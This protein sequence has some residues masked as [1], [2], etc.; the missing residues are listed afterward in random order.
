MGSR[1][2][3]VDAPVWR[4]GMEIENGL[5]DI[6]REGKSGMNGEQYGNYFKN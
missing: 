6:V 4:K 2:N 3:G 5:L 1:K